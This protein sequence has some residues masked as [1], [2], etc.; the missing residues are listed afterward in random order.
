M[1]LTERTLINEYQLSTTNNSSKYL[2]HIYRGPTISAFN[3][4][5]LSSI[6]TNNE[7]LLFRKPNN[8]SS[9]KL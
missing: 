3:R 1:K 6:P 5:T 2:G 7:V 8:Y 4:K 9:N